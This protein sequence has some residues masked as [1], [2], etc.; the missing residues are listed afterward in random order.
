MRLGYSYNQNPIPAQLTFINLGS[1]GV[2]QHGLTMG[3]TY[4][5]TS[6]LSASAAWVHGFSRGITGP[7]L[8]PAGPVPGTDVRAS[9]VTDSGVFGV[10][11]ML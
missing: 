4:R 10:S 7:Y 9:Q 11:L 6:R 1:S 2:F 5:F 3:A 8:T